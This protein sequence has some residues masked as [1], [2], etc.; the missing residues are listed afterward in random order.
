MHTRTV[1]RKGPNDPRVY[2]DGSTVYGDAWV[3]CARARVGSNGPAKYAGRAAMKLD[4]TRLPSDGTFVSRAYCVP[5]CGECGDA[6]NAFIGVPYNGWVQGD[7]LVVNVLCA[8]GSVL[9]S[10]EGKLGALD[11][12]YDHAHTLTDPSIYCFN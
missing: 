10:C 12:S 8:G 11:F 5:G 2:S 7:P 4:G 9:G 6:T 1:R 3:V